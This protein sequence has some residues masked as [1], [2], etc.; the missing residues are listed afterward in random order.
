MATPSELDEPAPPMHDE[1]EDDA[2]GDMTSTLESPKVDLIESCRRLFR[3]QV[4]SSSD[5]E[6]SDGDHDDWSSAERLGQKM[7]Q[8]RRR[9][10]HTMR[11]ANQN[12][13]KLQSRVRGLKE[14]AQK[15][16]ANVKNQSQQM[17]R[18]TAKQTQKL[19]RPGSLGD[20]IKER[21]KTFKV[22]SEAMLKKLRSAQVRRARHKV[23]FAA[24]MM[25]IVF[26]AYLLGRSPQDMYVYHTLKF[27]VLFGI[28]AIN[29]GIQKLHYYLMDFCYW[30]NL[31]L[32]SYCWLFPESETLLLA[33]SGCCG[34]L[35]IAAFFLRNSY[36]M[37]SIDRVT[38]VYSHL[39]P[40]LTCWTLMWVKRP[41]GEPAWTMDAESKRLQFAP[42]EWRQPQEAC[43]W[44]VIWP[45]LLLYL[46]WATI[47]YTLQWVVLKER[48]SKFQRMTLF[49]QM[50]QKYG[51]A[52][53]GPLKGRAKLAYV[54]FHL[55]FFLIGQTW[56][57]VLSRTGQ[58]LVLLGITWCVFYN[59][60]NYYI[61]H[62][63]KVYEQLYN[64]KVESEEAASR[65][66]R[67]ESDEGHDEYET[68]S[69]S[70]A[71]SAHEDPTPHMS[72]WEN[73]TEDEADSKK[74]A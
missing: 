27:F 17:L 58:A 67:R 41:D 16:S 72:A 65:P 32:L 5:V 48:I 13:Q 10:L 4:S 11:E 23:T 62:F 70:D 38:T 68:P 55:M 40:P 63:W 42:R 7:L 43:A 14:T 12:L 18:N 44:D 45:S 20:E 57:Y 36:V 25:D 59:G 50:E 61:E 47:N 26:T 29:Y 8:A 15:F 34:L 66:E 73:D 71:H 51:E 35:L 74:R 64:E 33:A 21:Q 69:T 56:A 37:H 28:R 6:G 2:S 31:A 9:S 39:S 52:L 19:V 3:Q 1:R 24:A 53:P 46:T 22:Q 30:P 49:K 54:T 60:G